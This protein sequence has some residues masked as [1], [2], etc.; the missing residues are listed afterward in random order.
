MK[1]KFIGANRLVLYRLYSRADVGFKNTRTS[2]MRINGN[3][4]IIFVNLGVK[5]DNRLTTKGLIHE[6]KLS[7]HI[8]SNNQPSFVYYL[9]LRKGNKGDYY[10]VG[11]SNSQ[12]SYNNKYNIFDFNAPGIPPNIV[13]ELGGFQPLP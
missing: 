2:A 7:V 10:Y 8:F 11:T 6:P 3:E 12:K 9:F 13:K 1:S 5:Y 4:K